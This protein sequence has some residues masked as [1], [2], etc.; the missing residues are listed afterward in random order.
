MNK[1]ILFIQFWGGASYSWVPLSKIVTI[2]GS[3]TNG[4]A[5]KPEGHLLRSV[6]DEDTEQVKAYEV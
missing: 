3:G 2:E 1:T 4:G 5:K 6:G